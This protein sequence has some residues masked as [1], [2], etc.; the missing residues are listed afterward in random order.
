MSKRMTIE[1]AQDEFE[2]IVDAL[3][4]GR[5]EDVI[6]TDAS[7]TDLARL[8]AVSPEETA[9]SDDLHQHQ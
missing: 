9:D 4:Q 2:S 8:V 1:Q 3:Q 7:G 6:L 5:I